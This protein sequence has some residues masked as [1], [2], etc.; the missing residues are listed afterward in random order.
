MNPLLQRFVHASVYAITRPFFVWGFVYPRYRPR[1]D[2][3]SD[4]MPRPPY[5]MVSNHG[6]FIDPWIVGS[7][8]YK[9]VFFMCND[10]AWRSSPVTQTYLTCVGAFPKRKGGADF[11]AIKT[12]LKILESGSPVCIFPEGQTS[13][14]GETQLTYLGLEKLVRRANV[15]LVIFNLCGNFLIKPWWAES[16]RT[17]RVIVRVKVLTPERIAAMNDEELFSA[18]KDGIYNNDIKD[19]RNDTYP[20]R[21]SGLAV[22][23]ERLAWICMHCG[24]E[25]RLSTSGDDITCE[26]CGKSWRMDAHCRLAALSEGAVTLPDLKD[27]CDMQR[28]K[29]LERTSGAERAETLAASTGVMLQTLGEDGYTFVDRGSGTL[30]VTTERLRFAPDSGDGQAMDMLLADVHDAVIQKKDIFEVRWQD[31]Y[32][33]FVFCRHSPIKWIYYVR[34]LQGY[35]ECEK[36]GYL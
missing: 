36:R 33:R 14:T 32:W 27:W 3:E 7:Y 13:W 23:L 31:T 29:V 4:R 19:P 16:R 28:T 8:T 22:G 35:E 17:G 6:T 30:S 34:Y 15:P 9:P 25:D 21:G 10:D 18:V 26:A 5:I 2:R 12:T 24:A 11:R 20:F 1:T